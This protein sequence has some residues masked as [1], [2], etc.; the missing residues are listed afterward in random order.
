MK[1]R[2]MIA[3][4]IA[5]LAMTFFSQSADAAVISFNAGLGGTGMTAGDTAGAPG[6]AVAGAANWNNMLVT[7]G[8]IPVGSVLDSSGAVV[9]GVA[10]S[11]VSGNNNGA[12]GGGS[13]DVQMFTSSFDAFT[14]TPSTT[15]TITGL[16][17]KYDVY[18]YAP[19]GGGSA[20]RGGEFSVGGQVRGLTMFDSIAAGTY[21]ESTA[22][23][24]V[25]GVTPEATFVQFAQVDGAGFTFTTSALS[26]FPRL[27]FSGFQIVNVATIP[28]PSSIL[29]LG[30]G[31][32]GLATRRRRRSRS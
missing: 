5:T 25:D 16:S 32:V 17:G 30:M 12:A 28:E 11:W 15:F 20:G 14:G 26:A 23:S 7:S 21:I 4:L 8:S 29:L 19:D 27:R 2:T 10:I 9:P 24:F 6:T 3:A 31:L 13:N 22:T 1:T 18:A